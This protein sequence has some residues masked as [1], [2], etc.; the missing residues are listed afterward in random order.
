MDKRL[1]NVWV[2]TAS[3]AV[4]A[5]LLL[6]ISF[7]GSGGTV[8]S[9]ALPEQQAVP[10]TQ[11]P[12]QTQPQQ[13]ATSVPGAVTTATGLQYIDEV[14][15][16]GAQPQ[17]GQTVVVHYTGYLDDGTVFDSSVQRNQPIE[18][19][20]GVGAVIP[21]WDEGLAAMKV[22]GKRKLIIPPDLAY[23]A[24]GY[25]SI[26]PNARLTFDVELVGVK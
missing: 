1:T 7:I 14:V 4:V 8:A 22:G 2:I 26:P 9:T 19:Q 12:A 20:F 21:G 15:G 10:S 13:Q 25:G 5:L 16:T 18:F 23:G 17:K 24:Q 11:N 6:A 3:V